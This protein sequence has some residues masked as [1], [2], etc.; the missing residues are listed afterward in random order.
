MPLIR[1][2]RLA[3][4]ENRKLTFITV[5]CLSS[6]I[7]SSLR[8][9][10]IIALRTLEWHKLALWGEES[11]GCVPII[12][13]RPGHGK[14]AGTNARK[15]HPKSVNILIEDV[16]SRCILW[17]YTH[18]YRIKQLYVQLFDIVKVVNI[19][20]LLIECSM[21]TSSLLLKQMV[22]A[23]YVNKLFQTEWR[24]GK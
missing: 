23:S 19:N 24:L 14:H 21:C 4:T 10:V 13:A 6:D 7:A 11:V 5:S 17:I 15:I 16:S 3:T 2:V 12:I 1:L 18:C 20:S 8:F 22:L 9:Q